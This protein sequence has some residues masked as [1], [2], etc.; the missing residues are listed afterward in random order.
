MD[1][2]R[3]AYVEDVDDRTLFENAIRGMLESLDPHSAYLAET[4]YDNLQEA[5]TGSFGGVG[6]EVSIVDGVVRVAHAA[7]RH[8]R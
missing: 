5:T 8:P 3:S 7:G 2:I 6:L 4:D 1:R